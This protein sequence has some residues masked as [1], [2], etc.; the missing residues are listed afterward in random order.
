MKILDRHVLL[1][2]LKNYLISFMVLIG[3]F[4]TLDMVFQFDEFAKVG[5]KALFGRRFGPASPLERLAQQLRSR[6]HPGLQLERFREDH[7]GR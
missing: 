5:R 7:C 3:L 2:F 1:S 6:K 4:V